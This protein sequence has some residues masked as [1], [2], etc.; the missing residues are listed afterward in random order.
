M[1]YEYCNSLTSGLFKENFIPYKIDSQNMIS[2]CAGMSSYVYFFHIL[3][4]HLYLVGYVFSY[5]LFDDICI[6]YSEFPMPFSDRD[7]I[8]Q[9]SFNESPS[10]F[11]IM[12]HSIYHKVSLDFENFNIIDSF[13]LNSN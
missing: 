4:V 10:E 6:M 12:S 3:L 8:F 7:G 13:R 9:T 5:S 11:I 1:D 2:Y